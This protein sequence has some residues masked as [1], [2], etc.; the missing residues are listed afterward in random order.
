MLLIMRMHYNKPGYISAAIFVKQ[1]QATGMTLT[2]VVL[3]LGSMLTC[4]DD[5]KIFG[6]KNRITYSTSVLYRFTGWMNSAATRSLCSKDLPIFRQFW[7]PQG[8]GSKPIQMAIYAELIFKGTQKY[9]VKFCY[10]NGCLQR[11]VGKFWQHNMV[12]QFQL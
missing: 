5:Y 2:A 9:T 7:K 1:L 3:S 4:D 6:F 8:S 11:Q 12:F 10:C